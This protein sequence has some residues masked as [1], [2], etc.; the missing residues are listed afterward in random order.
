MDQ[1]LQQD[2]PPLPV[3]HS[4]RL[5]LLDNVL[6]QIDKSPKPVR[7][8]RQCSLNSLGNGKIVTEKVNLARLA[9]LAIHESKDRQTVSHLYDTSPRA[10]TMSCLSKGPYCCTFGRVFVARRPTVFYDCTVLRALFTTALG[11]LK[12]NTYRFVRG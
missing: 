4:F 2:D 5:K 9:D 11:L 1:S 10:V 6:T 8:S 3:A 7:L 12:P